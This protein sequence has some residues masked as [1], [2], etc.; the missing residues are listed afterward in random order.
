MSKVPT[1]WTLLVVSTSAVTIGCRARADRTANAT[2][3]AQETAS[4]SVRD[5]GIQLFAEAMT[6]VF[7][8]DDPS[9]KRVD[10]YSVGSLQRRCFDCSWGPGNTRLLPWSE[11]RST[12]SP[13]AIVAS[14]GS[15][16]ERQSR[17][18]H[19]VR[20]ARF[21]APRVF[22]FTNSLFGGRSDEAALRSGL[23]SCW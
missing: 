1:F 7:L 10:D 6:V 2:R 11:L 20:L 21:M 9:I 8:L 18:S 4:E 16:D 13:V 14:A 17:I 15:P 3:E 12:E 19:A 23:L 22:W 5:A